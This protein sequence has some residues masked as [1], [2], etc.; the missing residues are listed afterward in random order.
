LGKPIEKFLL[1]GARNEKG[2]MT[3]VEKEKLGLF[4]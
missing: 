1:A 3:L 2:N 4:N